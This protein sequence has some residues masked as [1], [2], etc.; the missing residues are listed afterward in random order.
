[1]TQT[2]P[3][4]RDPAPATPR[5]NV[6]GKPSAPGAPAPDGPDQNARGERPWP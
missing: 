2:A 5:K 3:F 4:G 1:M 6:A